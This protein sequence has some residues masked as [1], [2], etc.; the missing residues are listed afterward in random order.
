MIDCVLD[1]LIAYVFNLQIGETRATAVIYF[2]G[3]RSAR[4]YISVNKNRL[5]AEGERIQWQKYVKY[6]MAGF[7][8]ESLFGDPSKIAK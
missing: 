1:F 6:H 4:V 8:F 3:E 5:G 7:V 2:C